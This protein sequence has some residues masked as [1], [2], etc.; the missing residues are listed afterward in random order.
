MTKTLT[1]ISA[2]LIATTSILTA[3]VRYSDP[4]EMK[5]PKAVTPAPQYK[6]EK[7]MKNWYIA[8]GFMGGIQHAG[9]ILYKERYAPG[10]PDDDGSINLRDGEYLGGELKLGHRFYLDDTWFV[11]AELNPY[12]LTGTLKGA[13][14]WTDNLGSS[15]TWTYKDRVDKIN[16]M[17]NMLIG[18][19]AKHFRLYAGPGLGVSFFDTANK[20]EIHVYDD[21][22]LYLGQIGDE[23]NP[24][25]AAGLAVQGVAGAEYKI[26]QSWSIYAEY[27][28]L[29]IVNAKQTQGSLIWR[30][31]QNRSSLGSIGIRYSF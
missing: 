15:G 28:Y 8:G 24:K 29:D 16:V 3:G 5:D 6:E 7:K 31:K 9:K 23:I 12:Y 21:Q 25:S 27:K 10:I 18:Y 11:A 30:N 20:P 4:K 2:V 19:D 14:H 1:T 13:G 22:G 17:L 26:S